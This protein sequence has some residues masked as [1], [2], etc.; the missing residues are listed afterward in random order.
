ME[1]QAETQCCL[2]KIR[3]IFCNTQFQNIVLLL[4][5]TY[6]ISFDSFKDSIIFNEFQLHNSVIRFY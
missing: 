6:L 4:K 3:P 1:L 5:R 2:S